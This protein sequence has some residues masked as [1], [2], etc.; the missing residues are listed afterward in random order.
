M[1]FE[2]PLREAVPKRQVRLAAAGSEGEGAG[3]AP[4]PGAAG[5]QH[6]KTAR[7][8]AFTWSELLTEDRRGL[9]RRKGEPCGAVIVIVIVISIRTSISSTSCAAEHCATVLHC[10]TRL[11]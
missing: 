6:S 3:T 2:A 8:D 9:S 11:A 10:K 7:Q 5:G 1:F 4:E